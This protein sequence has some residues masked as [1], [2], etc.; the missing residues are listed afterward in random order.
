MGI[1]SLAPINR[2]HQLA[3]AFQITDEV[4]FGPGS[5]TQKFI[6]NIAATVV[7]QFEICLTGLDAIKQ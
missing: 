2:L 6:D 3:Y 1:S 7:G 4:K 5:E